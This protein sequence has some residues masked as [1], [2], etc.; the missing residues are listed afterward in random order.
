M[1]TK[2]KPF[3]ALEHPKVTGNFTL[4][5][6]L[7]G[8]AIQLIHPAPHT[9]KVG[10]T[11]LEEE[12]P[13]VDGV[14]KVTLNVR[15]PTGLV[16][17]AVAENS[18]DIARILIVYKNGSSGTGG[19]KKTPSSGLATELYVKVTVLVIDEGG[20]ILLE[21]SVDYG[22]VDDIVVVNGPHLL[23]ALGNSI[24][25]AETFLSVLKNIAI[26]DVCS[27]VPP[28]VVKDFANLPLV[29]KEADRLS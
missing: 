4:V 13:G 11:I 25:L 3:R 5:N 2:A 14:N 22:I 10:G 8:F 7:Q 28:V 17:G 21:G 1:R 29:G 12:V 26:E 9:F 23:D 18:L 20:T 19:T 15:N 24:V 6:N 27:K 16:S